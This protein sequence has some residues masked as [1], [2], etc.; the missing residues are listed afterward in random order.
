MRITANVKDWWIGNLCLADSQ[1]DPKARWAG[2]VQVAQ[3]MVQSACKVGWKGLS[4]SE[5]GPKQ[6]GMAGFKWLI[7]WSILRWDESFYVAQK[8]VQSRM[9]W[10]DLSSSENGLN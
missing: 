1:S 4:G 9:G 2:W 8:M 7:K 3:K 6:D 10:K 5:N